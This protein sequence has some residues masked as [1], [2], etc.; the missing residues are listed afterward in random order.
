MVP[1]DSFC[2]KI[3]ALLLNT[4]IDYKKKRKKWL[5]QRMGESWGKRE[6]EKSTEFA[7]GSDRGTVK[8]G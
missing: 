8:K 2:A 7:L 3:N 6:I 5:G 4:A 1:C